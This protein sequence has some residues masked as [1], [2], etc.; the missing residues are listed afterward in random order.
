MAGKEDKDEEV[1]VEEIAECDNRRQANMIAEFYAETRNEFEPIDPSEFKEFFSDDLSEELSEIL[2]SPSKIIEVIKNMNK[3]SSSIKGDIPMKLVSEFSEEL[4]LPLTHIVNCIFE[5]NEYPRLW[6]TEILTPIPKCQPASEMSQLRPI[7]GVF[8]FARIFDRIIAEYMD[9]FRDPQQYGNQKGL[10][11][12]HYLI[13]LIN[14]I[15]T[16]LD[17]NSSTEKHAALLTMIDYSRAYERQS[18]S[19]GVKSFISNGVRKRLIPV[20]VN[21]FRD[22]QIQVKWNGAFSVPLAV[23]GGGLQGGNA[24]GIL[25]FLSRTAHNLS[26]LDEDSAWKYIDDE[27]FIEILNLFQGGLSKYNAR[28]QVPSDM[29]VSDHYLSSQN[30]KTQSHLNRISSW[31]DENLFKLNSKKTSYMIFNFCQSAQFQTRLH[32]KETLLNQVRETRL[33]GVVLRDDLKWSS[34]IDE[35]VRRAYVRMIILRNLVHFEVSKKDQIQIYKMFIRSIV[36]QSCVVWSASI[37]QEESRSLERIQKC[38]LKLIYK[39]KYVT[40]ENALRLSGLQDLR[41]R[42]TELS[43]RFALKCAENPKTAHMFPLNNKAKV[44]RNQEKFL[45]PFAY[46]NRLRD[47]AIPQMARQLNG[48]TNKETK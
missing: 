42:R 18:H 43:L 21:F 33:L 17:K 30:F 1:Y 2:V 35:L 5:T 14:K 13:N 20:L 7:S 26:F 47:S 45:V 29:A 12:N 36:E 25:E 28:W 23:A 48:Q 8:L 39:E 16:S 32:V 34:N 19:L 10:S 11:V 46:H 24:G 15:L 4:S 27:S 3:K 31:T 44:T 9:K 6:K 37:T 40:Y 41:S 38:C 22:R